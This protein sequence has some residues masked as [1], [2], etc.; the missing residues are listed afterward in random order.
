MRAPPSAVLQNHMFLVR[1]RHARLGT[2]GSGRGE[3]R[4]LARR[5]E[6]SKKL[7]RFV[8]F[9]AHIIPYSLVKSRT[10]PSRGPWRSREARILAGLRQTL[11][12]LRQPFTRPES[13]EFRHSDKPRCTR[14]QRA[15]IRC[16]GCGD[17]RAL[18]AVRTSYPRQATSLARAKRENEPPDPPR[19]TVV[20]TL[21][22]WSKSR[23]EKPCRRTH[24][25]ACDGWAWQVVSPRTTSRTEI[26]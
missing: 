7:T 3:R 14:V 11:G 22:S 12:C 16:G 23:T 8:S 5:F 18:H 15:A 1:P 6:V 17:G 4:G 9:R 26:V 19:Q 25:R 10:A 2:W 20:N 21:P 24:H 13:S